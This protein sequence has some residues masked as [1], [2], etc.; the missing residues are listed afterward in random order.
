MYEQYVELIWFLVGVFVY[1]TLSAILTYGHLANFVERINNQ[2]LTLLG[3]VAADLSLARE[4]K[5]KHLKR[6]G[7]SDEEF[8]EVEE[9][10]ERVFKNWKASAIG[11]FLIHFP[12]NYRF[13]VKYKDWDGAMKELERVY[14]KDIKSNR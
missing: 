12:K 7:I 3:T 5:Y 6:S 10:D 14:R 1:R 8:E 13:L 9:I 4:L 2:S 11:N